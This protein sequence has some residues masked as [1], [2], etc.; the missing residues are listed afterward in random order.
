MGAVAGFRS[1]VVPSVAIVLLTLASLEMA[2]YSDCSNLPS[3]LAQ[4]AS[5]P[6]SGSHS[7]DDCLCCCAHIVIA[8]AVYIE[9]MTI[10]VPAPNPQRADTP[11]ERHSSV[12]H[13][14]RA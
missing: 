14:P 8:A 10:V 2:F 7:G 6:T 4:S 5:Q 12:F 9:P 3:Q 13:P 11:I 1:W